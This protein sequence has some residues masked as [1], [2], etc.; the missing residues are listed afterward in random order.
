[1]ER[2]G[3][4]MA[5]PENSHQSSGE[6]GSAATNYSQHHK[7]EEKKANGIRTSGWRDGDDEIEDYLEGNEVNEGEAYLGVC[8]S[9]NRLRSAL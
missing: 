3:S 5:R 7:R 4:E 1:M 8:D 6:E 9:I 2:D